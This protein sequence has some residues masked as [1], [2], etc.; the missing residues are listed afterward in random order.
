[1]FAAD[2]I[3]WKTWAELAPQGQAESIYYILAVP[4]NWIGPPPGAHRYSGLHFKIGRSKNVLSRIRDL[5]TGTSD[6]LIIHAMEPGS[7]MIEA[8]LHQRFQSERRQG[9]WFAASPALSRH[10]Y[11]VWQKNLLLPP[12]HQQKLVAFANKSRMLAEVRAAG[13]NFDMV[14]PS[15]NEPWVGSVFVDL[16]NPNIVGDE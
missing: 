4:I 15:L 7:S 16:T 10:V 14:N 12:E 8:E 6:D 1:M 9:E 3:D 11:A 5:R 13:F 2:C